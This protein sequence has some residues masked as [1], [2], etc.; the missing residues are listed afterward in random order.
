[1]DSLDAWHVTMACVD[2][3]RHGCAYSRK[4]G[5]NATSVYTG[6]VLLF[7]ML[8]QDNIDERHV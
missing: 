6:F 4:S 3:S 7:V 5:W 1:M 8:P 2:Y